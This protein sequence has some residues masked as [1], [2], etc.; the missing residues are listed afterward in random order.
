MNIINKNPFILLGLLILIVSIPITVYLVK[1]QQIF[2]GRALT[3]SKFGIQIDIQAQ[4]KIPNPTQLQTLNPALARFV[5]RPDKSLPRLISATSQLVIFNNESASPAPI[6]NSNVSVWR[7]YVDT[8]YIP[9]LR[10]FLSYLQKLNVGGGLAATSQVFAIEIWNEEDL[11]PNQAFCPRVPAQAYAY[12]LR[13]AA[14]L[15]KSQN[16]S[17][18]VMMGGLASGQTQYVSD[19]RNADP[20]VFTQVDAVGLHPYGK[21]PDGWCTEGSQP[22]CNGNQL[23]FGDLAASIREYQAVAGRPIWITE[24]GYGSDD[25]R[26]QA[27]YLRRIFNVFQQENI[28]VA[29]WYA[30]TDLMTGGNTNNWGLFDTQGNLKPSGETFRSFTIP[31]TPTP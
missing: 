14:T 24:V 30:W 27:E 21:S 8:T 3:R 2:K 28:P 11:C 26:W 13:R 19:V 16:S 31:I 22:G 20:N 29:I 18:K 4:E 9:K 1:K 10:D 5:Q 12:M 17:L 23:P 15:I 7:S 25:Q 6:G